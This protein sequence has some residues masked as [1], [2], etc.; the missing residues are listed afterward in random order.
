M[1]TSTLLEN[2]RVNNPKAGEDFVTAMEAYAK[3]PLMSRTD[4]QRS[5]VV[6]DPER[7]R[8]FMAKALHNRKGQ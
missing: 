1:A 5:G 2:I 8:S 3:K 4:D 6:T 7:L